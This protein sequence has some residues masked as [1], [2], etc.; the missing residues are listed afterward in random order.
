MALQPM[1]SNN[2]HDLKQ[3]SNE[4]QPGG[5]KKNILYSKTKKLITNQETEQQNKLINSNLN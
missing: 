2:F 3:Y 4:C 1:N 5:R